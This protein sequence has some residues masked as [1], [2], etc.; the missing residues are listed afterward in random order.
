MQQG[1]V[2]HFEHGN[3][4]ISPLIG[5]HKLSIILY[6]IFEDNYIVQKYNHVEKLL[7]MG[8]QITFPF[9][10]SLFCSALLGY[11]GTIFAYGQVSLYLFIV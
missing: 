1:P 2:F 11:N 3:P 4:E 6:K 9:F 8:I 7:F 10:S 5:L